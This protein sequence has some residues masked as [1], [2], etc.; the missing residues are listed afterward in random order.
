[1]GAAITALRPYAV[2]VSSGI[3]TEG[4]KDAA[5]MQ[6]FVA[7]VHGAAQEETI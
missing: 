7:A 4:W 6:K 1:M 2:D 3:E 5:K